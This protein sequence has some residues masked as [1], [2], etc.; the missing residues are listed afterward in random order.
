MATLYCVVARSGAARTVL[1]ALCSVA[2]WEP[3][4]CDP[5]LLAGIDCLVHLAGENVAGGRWTAERNAPSANPVSRAR[6]IVAAIARLDAAARPAAFVCASAI[7]YYGDRGEES[8]DESLAGLG[9]SLRGVPRMEAQA[10]PQ[11]TSASARPPSGSGSSSARMAA[12]S[13]RCSRL[14]PA[15]RP[16]RDGR[17]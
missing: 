7:G 2:R 13:R 5:A 6:A 14:P 12:L 16:P 4:A 9:L 8:L 15:R 3:R 11:S 1:P 17:Q 10:L